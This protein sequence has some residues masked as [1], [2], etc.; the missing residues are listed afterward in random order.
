M[1]VQPIILL[2]ILLLPTH[3]VAGLMEKHPKSQ[4]GQEPL[5][6]LLLSAHLVAGLMG[7]HAKSQFSPHPI[8]SSLF[9]TPY[10][11]LWERILSVCSAHNLAI[12]SALYTPYRRAHGRHLKCQFNL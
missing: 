10:Q 12:A 6:F 3:L 11:G 1:S 8:S 2:G 9:Y 4:F 5:P 7:R